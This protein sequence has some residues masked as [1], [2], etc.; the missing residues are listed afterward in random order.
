[1]LAVGC[2]I[3]FV[4]MAVGAGVGSYL[5]DISGGYWGAGVGFGAGA[6]IAAA[7][8]AILDRTRSGL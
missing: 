7:G 2:L 8:F 3:P 1:M 5:G 6:I 4:L